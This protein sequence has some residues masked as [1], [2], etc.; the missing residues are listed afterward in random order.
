VAIG[1]DG[2]LPC[3]TFDMAAGLDVLPVRTPSTFANDAFEAAVVAL[4]AGRSEAKQLATSAVEADANLALGWIVLGIFDRLAGRMADA[5]E[6]VRQAR[7]VASG[8]SDREE[9]VIRFFEHFGRD[10]RAAETIAVEHLQ[11]HPRDHLIVMYTHFLYNIVL[12]DA[13]RRDRHV[14][15]FRSLAPLWPDDDWYMQGSL[16][17]VESEAGEHER[18]LQLARAAHERRPDAGVVAH[19]LSHA[20]LETGRYDEGRQWLG[21]WLT[22]WGDGCN[23]GCHLTWHQ[24]LFLLADVDERAVAEHVEQI[25]GFAGRSISALSDGASLLWRL[26]IDGAPLD[27]LPWHALASLPSPPGFAFGNLHRGMVLAGLGDIDGARS[28]AA[29]IP[30]P[31]DEACRAITDFAAGDYC[32]VAERLRCHDRDLVAIGGSRAQLEVLDDTL[33]AAMARAGLVDDARIRLAARLSGRASERDRRW[34]RSLDGK[35]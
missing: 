29:T 15:L 20:L 1:R 32:A 28:Y 19:S 17:F 3:E 4:A 10:N 22:T 27:S 16:A 9:S 21:D 7:S 5:A 35:S 30:Y 13:A 14:A 2:T 18:S 26:H 12:V 6:H 24:S 23:Q 34:L 11:E 31:A 8:V 25:L 33:I